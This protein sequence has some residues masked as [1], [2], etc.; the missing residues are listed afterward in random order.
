MKI[1][2]PCLNKVNV[3]YHLR[4]RNSL[5]VQGREFHSGLHKNV[6]VPGVCLYPLPAMGLNIGRYIMADFPC[7]IA[8][9]YK[10]PVIQFLIQ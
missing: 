3:T 6:K 8:L 1:E 2:L 9:H 10:Y 5:G 7:G 4:D